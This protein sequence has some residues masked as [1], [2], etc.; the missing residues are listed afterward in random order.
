MA[1][2]ERQAQ[3]TLFVAAKKHGKST[4]AELMVRNHYYPNALIYKEGVNVYDEAFK[5]YPVIE[6]IYSYKGGKVV[7]NGGFIRYKN[8]LKLVNDKFRNG[9]LMLDDIAEYER[10]DISDELWPILVNN[11]KLGIEVVLLYQGLTDVPIR[12]FKYVNTVILGYTNDGFE[13]KLNKFPDRGGPFR[14]AAEKVKAIHNQC[15]CK[16]PCR[17]GKRYYREIIKL[18]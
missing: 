8:F 3:V 4:L 18:S 5:K 11:R 16:D 13:Y 15:T 12:M 7:V 6:D 1:S 14:I 9:V 17:C 2:Q 10:N